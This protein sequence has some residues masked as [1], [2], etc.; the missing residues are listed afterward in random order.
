MNYSS[1]VSILGVQGIIQGNEYRARCPL[2]SD[3]NPSFSMNL[4]SGLWKCH[5][6]CGGGNF[7]QLVSRVLNCSHQEAVYWIN[8]NGARSS[9]DQLLNQLGSELFKAPNGESQTNQGWMAYYL[10]LTDQIMPYWFLNRGF[11]WKT[12]NHW[13]I[14]YD[15][16]MDSI[17]VPIFWHGEM[18]GIVTRNTKPGWPKY[19][20]NKDL[21]KAKMLFGEISNNKTDIIIVEG[22]LDTIWLWQCGFNAGG[23]LGDSLSAAQAE[24]LR[25]Y[26]F[27]EVILGLDNDEA[28]RV[29]RIEAVKLLFKAG[30]M[31]PQITVMKYPNEPYKKDAQD[32]DCDLLVQIYNDR[33]DI[34][35]DQFT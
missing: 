27:G 3:R 29:G 2:H 7:E 28:G 25:G 18:I 26:R 22:L 4:Q 19:E 34:T 10:S 11:T 31:L 12:I 5:A 6:R 16:V 9:A 14:K 1:L 23:I 30:W 32:C 20:N 35:V 15:P 17:T 24:I 33:K 8:N 21:P 13:K